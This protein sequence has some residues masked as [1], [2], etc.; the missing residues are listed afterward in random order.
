MIVVCPNCKTHYDLQERLVQEPAFIARCTKCLHVFSAYQPV[1]VGQI[2]FLNLVEAKQRNALKNVVAISNQKGGVAKTTTCLNLGLSL[3]LNKKRVLLV[4]FDIQANLTIS[5][6]FKATPSFIDLLNS[7]SQNFELFVRQTQ[8]KNLSLFP[9]NKNM[10]M[11][12]KRYF[13]A[14]NFEF[15]LKDRLLPIEDQ[16]DY[17][18]IDTP[19]SIEFFTLNA[20]TA[21]HLVVIPS[22]CDYLSTHGVDQILKLIQLIKAKT[23][24]DINSRILVTMFEKENAASEMIYKKLNK[25]YPNMSFDTLIEM[26]ARIREAQIM[27]MPVLA[28]NPQSVAGRQYLRL[29]EEILSLKM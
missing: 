24:P 21:A 1:R 12:N 19:P 2:G 8:Y 27:S 6:G 29:A 26:D 16:Y 11:L 18:L 10:V 25:L 4:D 9:S 20:L 15:I 22:Q 7:D 23:N 17:I 3:A 28:Y 13:G 14:R 5:L